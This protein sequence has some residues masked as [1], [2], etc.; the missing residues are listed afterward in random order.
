MNSGKNGELRPIYERNSKRAERFALLI[1]VGL[2]VEIADVFIFEKPLVEALLTIGSTALILTGVW[3]EIFFERRAREAGDGIVAQA[4]ARA[5]EAQSETARLQLEVT[6]LSTP[7]AR[8]LTP[9]ASASI[10]EKIRPFAETTYVVGHAPVGREQW[11]FA[12]VLEPLIS[13]AEWFPRDW[14]GGQ[15]FRK[16]NWTGQAHTY[17]VANVSNVTIELNPQ[18]RD[19]LLPAANALVD[20][21]NAVGIAAKVE[22]HPISGTSMTTDA[23]HLLIGAK[24]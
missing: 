3:G 6:R 5:A 12:W 13:S 18:H 16:V 1:L 8:L 17:G 7:R 4:N 19:A 9:E 14:I 11:D 24:E 21:L 22:D 20:A 15:T 2:A 10:V 23:I